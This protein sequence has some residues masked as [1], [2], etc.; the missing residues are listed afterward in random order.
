MTC[1]FPPK[2]PNRHFL[3]H[4]NSEQ[5]ILY[6]MYLVAL[7]NQIR[8]KN[9]WWLQKFS[10]KCYSQCK[11]YFLISFW[12]GNSTLQVSRSMEMVCAKIQSLN[13]SNFT[14]NVLIFEYVSFCMAEYN[15]HNIEISNQ[16][17]ELNF[18]C[19]GSLFLI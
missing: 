18:L 14:R 9:V 13:Y 11:L 17:I 12:Q 16:Q 10:H 3:Y 8:P 6:T 4:L 7:I 19:K 2:K 5:Y 15:C 1:I